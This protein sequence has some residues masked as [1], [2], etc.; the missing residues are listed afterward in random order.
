MRHLLMCLSVG[1]AL[2]V[3]CCVPAGA[4]WDTE[5]LP[6]RENHPEFR[7][8]TFR[9]HSDTTVQVDDSV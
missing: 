8:I 2:L 5:W 7:H 3:G 6:E 9:G 1:A 4:Q